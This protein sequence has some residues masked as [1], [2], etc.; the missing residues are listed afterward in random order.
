MRINSKEKGSQISQWTRMV[1]HDSKQ[2]VGDRKRN[3]VFLPKAERKVFKKI[4]FCRNTEST[5]RWSFCRKRLFLPKEDLLAKNL[6]QSWHKLK[7]YWE[8]S[9][10]ETGYF[11]RKKTFL[12][13]EAVSAAVPKGQNKTE[14]VSAEFL[15]KFSAEIRHFG[16]FGRSL[17]CR[18]LKHLCATSL[19]ETVPQFKPCALH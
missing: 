13:K 19:Y 18:T 12:P 14:R 5:E 15:P 2:V 6:G 4:P 1:C 11:C 9:P 8:D 10:A 7:A 3:F 16:H 17:C